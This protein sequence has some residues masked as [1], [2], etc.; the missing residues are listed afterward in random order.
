MSIG[1]EYKETPMEGTQ[2]RQEGASE[3]VAAGEGVEVKTAEEAIG[4]EKQGDGIGSEKE[5]GVDD[6]GIELVEREESD[7]DGDDWRETVMTA[8]TAS[9]TDEI[10]PLAWLIHPWEADFWCCCSEKWLSNIRRQSKQR[11]E[12]FLVSPAF[13]AKDDSC[14]STG[15]CAGSRP[16][17]VVLQ[18]L[19]LM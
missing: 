18:I 17:F 16:S 11:K 2:Q 6:D 13:T 9:S 14:S 3:V 5:D 7:K 12:R 1:N 8:R 4:W 10:M 19:H 15:V